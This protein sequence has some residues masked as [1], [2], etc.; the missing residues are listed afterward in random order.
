M[1][2]FFSINVFISF[3]PN[4][5]FQKLICGVLFSLNHGDAYV[6]H[7]DAHRCLAVVLWDSEREM[8]MDIISSP[9]MEV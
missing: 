6:F 3:F 9:V 4:H 7:L 2:T 5:S 8:C 1:K